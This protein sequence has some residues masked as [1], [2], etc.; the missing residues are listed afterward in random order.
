M[1]CGSNKQVISEPARIATVTGTLK[2]TL[3]S[4]HI[5]RE[6]STVFSM[7]PYAILTLSNQKIKS[8]VISKGGIDPKFN[9]TFS[10]TVNS[11]YKSHG[12]HLSIQLMDQN[13]TSD[14]EIGYGMI[15]MDPVVNFKLPKA[16]LRCFIN[17]KGE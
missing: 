7:D 6:T 16:E 1:G 4:A 5:Q 17:Y 11:C 10:F 15:D 2:I 3:V 13:I 8:K 12:R 14:S 9:Q